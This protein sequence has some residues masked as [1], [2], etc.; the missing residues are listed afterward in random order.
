[1]FQA[2]ILGAAFTVLQPSPVTNPKY[3]CL[4]LWTFTY[5]VPLSMLRVKNSISKTL[6]TCPRSCKKLR[7]EVWWLLML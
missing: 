5:V 2:G 4:N 6:K 1:M 7:T 3:L